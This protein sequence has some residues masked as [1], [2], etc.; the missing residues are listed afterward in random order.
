MGFMGPKPIFMGP[1]NLQLGFIILDLPNINQI[2]WKKIHF[3]IRNVR[4]VPKTHFWVLLWALW[5]Q[6]PIFMGPKTLILGFGT[7]GLP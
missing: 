7:S 4:N 3:F 1:K 2:Q 6:N 5:A